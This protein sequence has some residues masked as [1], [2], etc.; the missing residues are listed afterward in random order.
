VVGAVWSFS[1]GVGVKF[2][3]PMGSKGGYLK[4]STKSC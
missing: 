3:Q 4:K 1:S 2:A